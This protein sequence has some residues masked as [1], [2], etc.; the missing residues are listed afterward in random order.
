MTKTE[1][2]YL[3]VGGGIAGSLLAYNLYKAGKQVR[4]IQTS[5]KGEASSVSAGLINPITGKR[6]VKTWNWE[7]IQQ[8]FLSLTNY[9][10]G[11]VQF[12][13]KLNF[14]DIG[15]KIR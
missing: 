9:F 12:S 3:I 14:S 2:N 7:V 4:L 5:M 10:F 8:H 11:V 13:I 15:R 6:F 1:I